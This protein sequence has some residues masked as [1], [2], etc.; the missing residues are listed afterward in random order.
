MSKQDQPKEKWNFEQAREERMA[1]EAAQKLSS[2][3]K[4]PIREAKGSRV[5]FRVVAVLLIVAV[6]V[7]GAFALGLPQ[8]VLHPMSVGSEKISVSEYNFFYNSTYQ[9]YNQYVRQGMVPGNSKGELDMDA[10]TGFPEGEYKDLTWG[11]FV[12]SMTQKQIQRITILAMKA[13]EMKLELTDENRKTIE[14]QIEG[15]IKNY[16]GKLQAENALVKIYGRGTTLDILRSIQEKIMLAQR[17][18]TEYPKT[19]SFTEE[20]MTKQYED[21][22]ANYDVLD[23]RS[24]TLKLPADS[25]DAANANQDAAAANQEHQEK[26]QKLKET[27]EDFRRQVHDEASFVEQAKNYAPSDEKSKFENSDYTLHKGESMQMMSMNPAGSWLMNEERKAGDMEVVESTDGVQIVYFLKRYR[28]EDQLPT[29][30]R[31]LF[32]LNLD[33]NAQSGEQAEAAKEQ[34]KKSLV[35]RANESLDKVQ[36]RASLEAEAE[37]LQKDGETATALWAEN[38]NLS[39]LDPAVRAWVSDPARKSGDKTVIETQQGCELLF[40]GQP[41]TD[42]AWKVAVRNDLGQV[43]LSKEM[44]EW[45]KSE[46]YKVAVHSFAMRFTDKLA[47][48]TKTGKEVI[49]A[50]V[51][52]QALEPSQSP[53]QSS[54]ETPTQSQGHAG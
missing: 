22:R 49:E 27:A 31:M 39:V 38:L 29:V 51:K 34:A 13:R 23:Y 40:F 18:M 17:Y 36:D 5:L 19:F 16:G 54:V 15:A 43:K 42:P 45:E 47:Q 14:D 35:E 53:V 44:E 12:E 26:I 7:W 46:E 20:E 50:S 8:K 21:N 30:G 10:L 1:R 37:R 33:A 3:E 24:F 52:A 2:G 41:G 32:T 6:L 28:M 9:Q 48:N 11:E 4:R 25:K